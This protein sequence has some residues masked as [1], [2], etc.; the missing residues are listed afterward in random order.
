MAT[1]QS[2][3]IV[4][5]PSKFDL[6]LALFDRIHD[7]REITFTVRRTSYVSDAKRTVITGVDSEGGPEMWLFRGW[8]VL[9]NT[10]V[11]GFYDTNL[12]KGSISEEIS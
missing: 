12:R 10:Q 5:G 4:G 11:S 2:F 9:N 8:Y 6:M 7:N 3:K 1:Q